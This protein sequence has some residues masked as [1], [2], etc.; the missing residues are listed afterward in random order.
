[1]F[2]ILFII[3]IEEKKEKFYWSFYQRGGD[4][5]SALGSAPLCLRREFPAAVLF[6]NG[7]AAAVLQRVS[8][9]SPLR[10]LFLVRLAVARQRLRV[11]SERSSRDAADF[12][13]EA[14]RLSA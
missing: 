10:R 7:F 3:H 13:R 14:L 5:G 2:F 12:P 11:C 8:R 6:V 1:M 4:G 9:A